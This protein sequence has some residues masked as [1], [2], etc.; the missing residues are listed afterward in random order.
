MLG[1]GPDL[2]L[3]QKNISNGMLCMQYTVICSRN[4]EP[5]PAG[6]P[7]TPVPWRSGFQ[8]IDYKYWAQKNWYNDIR[9][10]YVPMEYLFS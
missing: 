9:T 6:Q 7:G 2:Y 8:P 10:Q 1:L 4:F 5:E 3:L